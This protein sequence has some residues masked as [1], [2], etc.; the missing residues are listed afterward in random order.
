[1]EINQKKTV[2][3]TFARPRS[4]LPDLERPFSIYSKP[5]DIVEEQCYVG[6]WLSSRTGNIWDTH[7]Q[8]CA[9]KARRAANVSFFVESHTGPIP[10]WQGRTLYTAQVA[11]HLTW[12]TEVTGVG[13]L[14]QQGKLD[15]VQLAYLRRLL[16]VQKR[17]QRCILF[18]ETGLW[19]M[20]FRRLELQLRYLQYILDLDEDH[21]ASVALRAE[22]LLSDANKSCWLGDLRRNLYNLG[23]DLGI[24]PS[25]AMVEEARRALKLA[26]QSKL[27][28]EVAESPKLD[29]LRQRVEY[30]A[31]G[32]AASPVMK[33]RN[34][35]FVR[36]KALRNAITRL[37]VSDHRLSVV[38]LRWQTA[39]VPYRIPREE[40]L[41]RFC[42]NAVEDP[43]HALFQCQASLELME[44]REEFWHLCEAALDSLHSPSAETRS[45]K[46]SVPR[47]P[48]LTALRSMPPSDALYALLATEQTAQ[49]LASYT[50]RAFAIYDST[51][52]YVP[53]RQSGW[54]GD[55]REN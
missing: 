50:M 44:C 18:T 3:M 51:G 14:T 12:G 6:V 19:P 54:D 29:I 1:M 49:V 7:F 16:G 20:L 31:T 42:I 4:K 10:P 11:P 9:Q 52:R 21:L 35:L 47:L 13:T 45:R 30:G 24:R 33:F 37:L 28:G 23:I 32:R 40:R 15:S 39:S 48:A 22:M 27:A 43:I 53:D 5:L 17:S 26:M 2:V 55:S 38:M 36:D 25:A 8:K 46:K 34:Y 41:C